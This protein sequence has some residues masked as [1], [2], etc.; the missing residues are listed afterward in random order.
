MSTGAQIR[1][2]I[3]PLTSD[4]QIGEADWD[5]SSMTLSDGGVINISAGKPND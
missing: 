4:G 3:M 1:W 2:R 5:F